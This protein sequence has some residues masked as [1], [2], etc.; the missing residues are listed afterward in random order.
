VKVT[1]PEDLEI[2]RRI[3]HQGVVAHGV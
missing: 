2:A 1:M 3:I